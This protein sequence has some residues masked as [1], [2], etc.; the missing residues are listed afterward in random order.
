MSFSI[1]SLVLFF[2]CILMCVSEGFNFNWIELGCELFFSF[3]FGGG[4]LIL[5][6]QS[7]PT[8]TPTTNQAT[9]EATKQPTQPNLTN[10][11]LFQ[12]RCQHPLSSEARL[13]LPRILLEED[14]LNSLGELACLQA[15]RTF[16]VLV[17]ETAAVVGGDKEVKKDDGS[18]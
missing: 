15:T 6:I 5:H 7:T 4:V 1:A 13:E 12:P 2:F 14:L 16:D 11:G 17:E 9:N 3:F 18:V 10:C 8:L